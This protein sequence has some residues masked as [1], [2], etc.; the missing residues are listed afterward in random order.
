MVDSGTFQ[1]WIEQASDRHRTKP[2]KS[3]ESATRLAVTAHN[4]TVTRKT[5][6]F[7]YAMFQSTT[8]RGSCRSVFPRASFATNMCQVEESVYSKDCGN[9]EERPC[10]RVIWPPPR[11]SIFSGLVDESSQ[12]SKIPPCH[13][14]TCSRNAFNSNS[15]WLAGV[16]RSSD[17]FWA[18]VCLVDLQITLNI[19][20]VAWRFEELPEH[21]REDRV[22]VAILRSTGWEFYIW[23]EWELFKLE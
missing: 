9:Y 3:D 8:Q 13:P 17:T 12:F 21:S 16:G 5:L 15:C 1:W 4:P 23:N 14:L 11:S 7:L 20:T 19:S 22:L 2:G 18:L 10:C 6:L